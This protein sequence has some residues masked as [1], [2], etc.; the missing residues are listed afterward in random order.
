MRSVPGLG[1][2]V[3]D[4]GMAIDFHSGAEGAMLLGTV[5]PLLRATQFPHSPPRRPSPP[6][7]LIW[8]LIPRLAQLPRPMVPMWSQQTQPAERFMMP[9]WSLMM[10]RLRAMDADSVLDP[11]DAATATADVPDSAAVSTARRRRKQK[12]AP[13]YAGRRQQRRENRQGLDIADR[14]PSSDSAQAGGD[15]GSRV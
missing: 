10:T 2:T 5:G 12:Y 14:A 1:P 11:E 8:L 7:L 6:P 3:G 9:T 4:T 15:G 13:A